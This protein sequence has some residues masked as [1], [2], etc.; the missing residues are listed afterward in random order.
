MRWIDRTEFAIRLIGV[1]AAAVLLPLLMIVRVLE[2]SLR[3]FVSVPT[4]L[5]NA[6]ERELFVLLIFLIIGWAYLVG[7]HV[8]VD[9]LRPAISARRRAWIECAG[10]VFFLLPLVV[11]TMVYGVH[12]AI[13]AFD[14]G[15]RSAVFF[16]APLRWVIVGALPF[17]IGLLGL[18][19]ICRLV[20]S[21]AFLRGRG[22]DPESAE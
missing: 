13:S 17:G 21:I 8:R 12:P 2:I 3:T 19:G 14:H 11:I 9:I 1:T 15:E 18:A 5:Y 4:S 22:P 6:M 7:A 20:R 16:G 10:I